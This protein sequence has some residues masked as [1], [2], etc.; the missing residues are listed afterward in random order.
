VKALQTSTDKGQEKVVHWE[1]SKQEK[2]DIADEYFPHVLLA[3]EALII[4]RKLSAVTGSKMFEASL[5]LSAFAGS[6][7]FCRG[8]R[9]ALEYLS[10]PVAPAPGHAMAIH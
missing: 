5:S 2:A 10:S 1:A 6:M 8:K 3:T 7:S 4:A 9:V